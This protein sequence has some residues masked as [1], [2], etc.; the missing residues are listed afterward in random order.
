MWLLAS[1]IALDLAYAVAAVTLPPVLLVAALPISIAGY[2]V[3]EG[4]YVLLLGHVGVSATDAT[5]FSLLAG[6]SFAIASLAGGLALVRRRA[7]REPL[8]TE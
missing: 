8:A 1:A 6:I 3:R 2:G 7:A 5:L 4:S